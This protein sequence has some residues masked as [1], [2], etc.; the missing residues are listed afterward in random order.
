MKLYSPFVYYVSFFFLFLTDLCCFAWWE[1]PLLYS[2]LCFYIVQL[3][4]KSI[5]LIHFIVP[6]FLVSLS[7][8]IY[9]GR[10]DLCLLY[11]IPL[12]GAIFLV[13]HS[14]YPAPWYPYLLI[15]GSLML[16]SVIIEYGIL[17]LKFNILYTI[18]RVFVNMIM[19]FVFS[20]KN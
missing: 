10:F 11:I 8:F 14:L 5:P 2:L 12:L 16:Q 15:A 7:S 6:A 20:L 13:R 9:Y 19:I 1:K 3:L 17:H 18:M 4:N